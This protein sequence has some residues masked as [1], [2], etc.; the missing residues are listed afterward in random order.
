MFTKMDSVLEDARRALIRR[1]F[2]QALTL[3]NRAGAIAIENKAEDDVIALILRAIGDARCGMEDWEG[4]EAHYREA[5]ARMETLGLMESSEAAG[6]LCN[7]GYLL[8]KQERFD[9]SD[10]LYHRALA[11]RSRLLGKDH[12]DMVPILNNMAYRFMNLGDLARAQ[13]LLERALAIVE[14]HVESD[15]LALVEP[16]NNLGELYRRL[17]MSNKAVQMTSRALRVLEPKLPFDDHPDLLVFLRNAAS[18]LRDDGREAEAKPLEER[19]N[20]IANG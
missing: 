2:Q 5:L 17:G 14:A 11:V 12:P 7:L 3:L 9:E 15:S 19:A 6:L 10:A 1:D 13:A 18:A 8:D 16:L 4:A 20:R